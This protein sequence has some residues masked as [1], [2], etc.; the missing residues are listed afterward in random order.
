MDEVRRTVAIARGGVVVCSVKARVGR[1]ECAEIATLRPS[2]LHGNSS[3]S[4]AI[5]SAGCP[6]C[7]LLRAAGLSVSSCSTTRRWMSMEA[8]MSVRRQRT[9]LE[10]T[11]RR[12]LALTICRF[13][14]GFASCLSS[15]NLQ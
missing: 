11:E 8:K 6:V 13:V 2:E 14:Q 12:N 15:T 1:V 7:A 5:R 10:M 4:Q 3:L 9:H